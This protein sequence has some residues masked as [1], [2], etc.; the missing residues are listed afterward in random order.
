MDIDE[1]R[2]LMCFYGG[3]IDIKFTEEH[4]QKFYAYMKLLLEWNEKINALA[5][6]HMD[7]VLVG[8]LVLGG[9]I[10]I[11]FYGVS[12]LNKK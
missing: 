9:L 2:E 3:R 11:G 8:T 1:F 4:I 5:G 7:N 12:A 10:F 6:E